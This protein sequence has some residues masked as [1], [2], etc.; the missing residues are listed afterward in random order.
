MRGPLEYGSGYENVSFPF[1]A[2]G[3]TDKNSGLESDGQVFAQAQS[4]PACTMGK[5]LSV[6]EP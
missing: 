1:L 2:A 4:S 5:F 3:E 6:S